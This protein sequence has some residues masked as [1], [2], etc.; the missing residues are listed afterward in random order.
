MPFFFPIYTDTTNWAWGNGAS[1]GYYFN[2]APRPVATKWMSASAF[3]RLNLAA[4]N[5]GLLDGI[6]H[7]R[8]VAALAVIPRV[9]RSVREHR[10]RPGSRRRARI[11]FA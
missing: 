5:P 8:P 6:V 9:F 7:C 4:L 2:A 1:P 10:L 11:A 3:A